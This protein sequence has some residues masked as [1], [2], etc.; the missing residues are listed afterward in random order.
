[1]RCNCAGVSSCCPACPAQVA[2]EKLVLLRC[3]GR[4][5]ARDLAEE[6]EE[7]LR[8]GCAVCLQVGGRARA[9]RTGERMLAPASMC[10][11]G[12]CAPPMYR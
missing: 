5:S 8:A 4:S 9:S 10:M 7:G 12:V 3:S 6:V 2:A 11:A 1:M